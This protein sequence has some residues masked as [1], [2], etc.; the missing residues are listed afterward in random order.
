[1]IETKNKKEI[2]V[3]GIGEIVWDIFP[4]GPH[5]GGAP[6]NFVYYSQLLGQKSILISRVGD[7]QLGKAAL[8]QLESN[9]LIIDYIQ[10]DKNHATGTVNVKLDLNGVP[11]FTIQENVAW[12]FLEKTYSLKS[13][14]KKASAVCFGSLA[15]RS[16]LSRETICWFLNQIRSDCLRV[17]DINL[18]PPFYSK[19][20]LDSL[21]RLANVLKINEWE[22]SIVRSLFFPSLYDENAILKNLIEIY[23]IDVIALT[24][25]EKG[26]RLIAA[27]KE[28]YHPGFSVEV[29]D[30][31]GAGDAFAAALVA[32]LLN[33]DEL[34]K[35][36][37]AA[38]W[39]AS[40]VCSQKGAWVNV[41]SPVP[42]EIL[43]QK[44]QEDKE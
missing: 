21:L 4:D 17:L 20:L 18:R 23:K 25:G 14:A 11:A 9:K 43:G 22:L 24:K 44:F 1:M 27:D 2:I 40:R 35:I 12:D 3:V 7:D 38:N 19:E 34:D 28:S 16:A 29:V 8:K 5:L 33:G 31:V 26:S 10:L 6:A 42:V 13:I 41:D 30:T 39:L 36:N 15:F 32:G 37:R